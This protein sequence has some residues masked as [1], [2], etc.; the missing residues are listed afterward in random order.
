MAAKALMALPAV[1][2]G[3]W[4]AQAALLRLQRSPAVEF[5]PGSMDDTIMES[6]ETGDVVFFQRKLSALQP[7]AALHT[8]AMR[9]V[10]PRFDHC[11]W[12]FVD[13]LGRKFVV[14]ETLAGVKCRA[15]S[16]R[17]L[18]SESCEIAV[19][20]LKTQRDRKLQDAALAFVSREVSRPSRASIRQ[21][22]K[23]VVDPDELKRKEGDDLLASPA[24]GELVGNAVV[25]K[26]FVGFGKEVGTHEA[27]GGKCW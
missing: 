4:S 27:S 17:I 18:A 6:L 19:L 14:E 21:F 16:A 25:A 20:P 23:A 3:A 22:I 26:Q 11:G 1:A 5:S 10:D 13:R 12:V 24:A 15:Y 2:L 9:R 8:L 7:L